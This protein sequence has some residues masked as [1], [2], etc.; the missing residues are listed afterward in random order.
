MVG[1]FPLEGLLVALIIVAVGQGI[2]V[3]VCW[4]HSRTSRSQ[5]APP[6]AQASGGDVRLSE[7]QE[8]M[9][10]SLGSSRLA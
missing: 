10:N 6:K 4:Y 1:D 9:D 5:E 7:V 8:G 3:G 2:V